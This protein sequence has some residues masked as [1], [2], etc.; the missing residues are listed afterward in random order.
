[1]I[2][3][4]WLQ[5]NLVNIRNGNGGLNGEQAN[6]GENDTSTT[7]KYNSKNLIKHPTPPAQSPNPS[8]SSSHYATCAPPQRFKSNVDPHMLVQAVSVAFKQAEVGEFLAWL[9]HQ[10]HLVVGESI[11]KPSRK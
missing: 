2:S 11:S 9:F 5:N 6:G 3:S 8:S 10:L 7:E 1:M 4:S